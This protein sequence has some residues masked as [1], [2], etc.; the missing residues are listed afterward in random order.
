MSVGCVRKAPVFRQSMFEQYPRWYCGHCC[1]RSRQQHL[2]T[3]LYSISLV[4]LLKNKMP[5]QKPIPYTP[6]TYDP[7]PSGHMHIPGLYRRRTQEVYS[8]STSQHFSNSSQILTTKC[9]R[10][11]VVGAGPEVKSMPGNH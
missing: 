10:K 9:F 7:L 2:K 11:N 5:R 1:H 4:S 8:S 6:P 3:Q